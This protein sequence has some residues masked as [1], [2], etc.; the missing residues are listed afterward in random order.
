MLRP[1]SQSTGISTRTHLFGRAWGANMS[2]PTTEDVEIFRVSLDAYGI[3]PSVYFRSIRLAF[4][5]MQ[6]DPVFKTRRQ[7]LIS[8]VLLEGDP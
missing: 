3:R 1:V 7:L 2:A 4:L 6:G 5:G 8:G